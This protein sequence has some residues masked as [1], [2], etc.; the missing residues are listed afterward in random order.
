MIV[1][2]GTDIIETDRMRLAIQRHG[3][4]FLH[5]IFT[6][7]E[8]ERAPDAP[9]RDSYF[10]ARWA[11]KEAVAKAL[12]TGIGAE[13][14]WTDIDV[15]RGNAGEPLVQLQG[16]AAET[17]RRRRI[18]RIHV[19]LSHERNLAAATAVAETSPPH[20]AEERKC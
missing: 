13:C 18:Q 14:A 15:T 9:A 16:A 4:R 5:Y 10:A 20:A 12:G 3:E 19:S 17:A 1:G 8:I 6:P 7:A 2:I 11:V